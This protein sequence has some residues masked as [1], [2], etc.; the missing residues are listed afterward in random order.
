MWIEAG[1]PFP[2]C[3]ILLRHILDHDGFTGSR[4]PDDVKMSEPILWLD[5]DRSCLTTEDIIP[6]EEPSS[7][8]IRG[9]LQDLK[10]LPFDLRLLIILIMRKVIEGRDFLGIEDLIFPSPRKLSEDIVTHENIE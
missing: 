8:C 5:I 7:R 3:D 2:S 1:N 6:E 4:L 10:S 9:S